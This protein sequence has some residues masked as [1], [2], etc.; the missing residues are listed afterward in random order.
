MP[1]PLLLD[2]KRKFT[3]GMTKTL[4]QAVKYFFA[5]INFLSNYVSVLHHCMP[6]CYSEMAYKYI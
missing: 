2:L 6:T 1:D 5:F 4:G 3:F